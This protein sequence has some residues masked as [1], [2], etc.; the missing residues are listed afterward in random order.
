MRHLRAWAVAWIVLF[1]L[2]IFLAGEW[3][4]Q[5]WVAAAGGAT[6]AASI[7]ELARTSSDARMRV[8]GRW[9]ISGWSAFLVVFSDFAIVMAALVRSA[10]RRDVVRGA[11]LTR[12]TDVGGDDAS[13]VG[14]R[15]WRNLL[16]N[17]SPNAYV[18]D[19]DQ[20][21]GVVVLHDLVPRRRSEEPA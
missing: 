2:W 18:V 5:E 11:F 1:W 16:A 17:Y 7:G 4:E 9:L 13:G 6:I 10:V 21:R 20:E 19:F 12:P 14:I 3:T 8:P 15:V